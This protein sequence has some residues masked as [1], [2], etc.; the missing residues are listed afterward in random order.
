VIEHRFIVAGAFQVLNATEARQHFG[1][2]D[3]RCEL[4]FMLPP[5]PRAA[6]E[7]RS[8]I[9]EAHWSNVRVVGPPS[10]SVPRWVSRVRNGRPL[11]RESAPLSHLFLGDYQT[12]LGRH[13]AHGVR[14]GAVVVLDDGQATLR[15]NAYRVARAEGR[16]P[17]RLHPQIPRPRYDI[18][19]A[20]ARALGLR[21][22]DLRSVTFFT[23]YDLTPARGDAVVRNRFTWLRTRYGTPTIV[24][25]SLFL[26]SPLVES[27]IV[28]HDTYVTILKRLQ[29]QSD[30]ALWYRPHPREDPARVA[31]LHDDV[32]FELLELDS[33]IEVGVLR[34]GWVPA[35]IATTHSTALDTLRVILGDAV[36]VQ[37]IPLP[38]EQ[39]APRWRDWITRAY[40]EMDARLGVPVERLELL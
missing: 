36:N 5:Q 17:P 30:G 7:T 31:R 35:R 19:R 12:H 37:A 22:G 23:V 28:S 33:I 20:F 38:I 15:V 24:A 11:R 29:A 10:T 21:L 13:A 1:L 9:E 32:G 40:D 27:A 18:Q 6:E 16:R 34:T 8:I 14:G 2:D 26:G 3:A 25:G 4:V 39:V